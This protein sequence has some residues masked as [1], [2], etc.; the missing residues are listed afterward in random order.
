M[1][2]LLGFGIFASRDIIHSEFLLEYVGDLMS[3]SAGDAIED[4]TYIYHF[5]HGSQFYW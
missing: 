4:Q 1:L 2:Y 3:S 5:Q